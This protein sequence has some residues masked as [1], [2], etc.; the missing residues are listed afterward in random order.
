MDQTTVGACG[1][2]ESVKSSPWPRGL[3]G[4]RQIDAY[5]ALKQQLLDILGDHLSEEARLQLRHAL[6]E[7][8]QAH[9]AWLLRLDAEQRPI[10]RMARRGVM[11]ETDFQR[12]SRF[13]ERLGVEVNEVRKEAEW[14]CYNS[15]R[16]NV[17][18]AAAEI[19]PVAI[20]IWHQR[21][22]AEEVR[23][24]DARSGLK[25]PKAGFLSAASVDPQTNSERLL[26]P[27]E[28][29]AVK[30]PQA[31]PSARNIQE[32]EILKAECLAE[33]TLLAA[34]DTMQRL[35]KA[36]MVRC[37]KQVPWMLRLHQERQ[38]LRGAMQ[39]AQW[40]SE[41]TPTADHLRNL[42]E[43]E[44][45]CITESVKVVEEANWLGKRAG[46]PGLGDRIWSVAFEEHAKHNAHKAKSEKLHGDKHERPVK[47]YA[48][49]SVRSWPSELPGFKQ[50]SS[51]DQLKDTVM[52]SSFSV[53]GRTQEGA[54]IASRLQSAL[55]A[56]CQQVIPLIHRLQA[57]GSAF[58]EAVER[59]YVDDNSAARF[60]AIESSV[61]LEVEAVKIE[62]EWLSYNKIWQAAFETYA[63]RRAEVARQISTAQ[64][65]QKQV[66][67]P[68]LLDLVG[69][70]S[71]H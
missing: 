26:L 36:L 37:Q 16:N 70:D 9:V 61:N 55:M 48:A 31:L 7:R 43:F 30:W 59:G 44:K 57:E 42:E 40:Q 39:R 14:L 21:G 66:P 19:W 32:Y 10:E 67:T 13:A 12:F 54:Q 63:D 27:A 62:A 52:Q 6:M 15:E 68:C 65:E 69:A 53:Q 33:A 17:D 4:M 71:V 24:H 2:F 34:G 25:G 23:R 1:K 45:I 11:S 50:R 60:R 18:L 58:K 64:R 38:R 46:T 5:D 49:V 8:C 22:H 51:Y 47:G 20:Q 29:K 35:K 56:R 28:F 3:P 41:G